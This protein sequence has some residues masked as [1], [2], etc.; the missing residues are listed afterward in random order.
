VTTIRTNDMAHGGDAVGRNEGKA[1]FINGALPNE[2]VTIADVDDRGSFAKARVLDVVEPSPE[3]VEPTCPHFGVCGGCQWQYAS[4]EGQLEMK[5]SIVEGQL[6]HLGKVEEPN[7]RPT[8]APGPPL[9]YRNKM[10]FT[11]VDGR[12]ALY[13]KR[14]HDL[15]PIDAC[16]LLVPQLADLYGRLGP[17]DGVK[18]IVLRAGTRTGDTLVIVEGRLPPQIDDWGVS[19]AQL[20]RGRLTRVIGADHIHEMAADVR[21]RIT[22]SAFF[23]VNT[24]GADA[25]V[26]L[27]G[28]ALEP[29]IDDVLMDAYSGGG[30]FT[31]TV[32][33]TAGR[34]I[35]IESGSEAVGDLEHNLEANECYNAEI[36]EGRVEDELL[37]PVDKWTI[38]VCDPPRTGLGPEVVAGM[39]QTRP[40]ALAYVSCDPASF[41]RDVWHFAEHGYRL[42]WVTPVDLFP[43]SFH[44][45]MV[46]SLVPQG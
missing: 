9:G 25:L 11:V 42:E 21:F 16:Q 36:V 38:A 1:Y 34:V 29:V 32:G 45:E 31:A 13:R 10:D 8:V 28:E 3:R 30:L 23:Q 6:R 39:V 44:V 46:G 22:G 4:Y 33:T 19:V 26:A 40:R 17:L 24:P 41:A 18:R 37:D 43:Q 27:V 2:T 35:A 12:A 7:V 14:S 20:H 15:E 5:R